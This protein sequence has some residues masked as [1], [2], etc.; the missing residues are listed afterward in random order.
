MWAF[1][2]FRL[3]KFYLFTIVCVHDDGE[4]CRPQAACGSHFGE[5]VLF[6][7][8]YVDFGDGTHVTRLLLQVSRSVEPSH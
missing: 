4:A 8:L 5:L 2:P 1:I 6:F 7:H 3:L